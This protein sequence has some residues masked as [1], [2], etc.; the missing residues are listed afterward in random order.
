[1]IFGIL[2]LAYEYFTIQ[3]SYRHFRLNR[4]REIQTQL[5]ISSHKGERR[6]NCP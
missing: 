6:E 1:M 2:K 4:W 5:D 3:D